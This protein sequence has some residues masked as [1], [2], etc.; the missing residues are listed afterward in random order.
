M[1]WEHQLQH[2]QSQQHCHCSRTKQSNVLLV[3]ISRTATSA[4]PLSRSNG[5][6]HPVARDELS[7]VAEGIAIANPP[8]LRRHVRNQCRQ[9]EGE[10]GSS[11]GEAA[12]PDQVD[13]GSRGLC[14]VNAVLQAVPALL[15]EHHQQYMVSGNH[16]S[17]VCDQSQRHGVAELLGLQ[18]QVAQVQSSGCLHAVAEEAVDSAMLPCQSENAVADGAALVPA[19][20]VHCGQ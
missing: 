1:S 2:H 17:G 8:V 10:V 7:P 15:Q 5:D 4:V 3:I 18:F 14:P 13:D 11:S 6:H 9:V 19:G 20:S 12:A 16:Q